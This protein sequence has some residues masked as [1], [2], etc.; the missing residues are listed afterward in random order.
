MQPSSPVEGDDLEEYVLWHINLKETKRD[1]FKQAYFELD[2]RAYDLQI[3]QSWKNKGEEHWERL[4]ILPDIGIQL[5]RDVSKYAWWRKK[6]SV[7]TSSFE[8]TSRASFARSTSSYTRMSEL[9]NI[10]ETQDLDETQ[11]ISQDLDNYE[12]AEEL[13]YDSGLDEL[14]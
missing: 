4:N 3:I 6:N 9:Q 10:K 13:Q 11:D 5:T 7:R 8:L 14:K 1:A 2:K 12:D